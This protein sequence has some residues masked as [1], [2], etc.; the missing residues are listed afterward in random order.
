MRVLIISQYFWPEDFRIND[1][2]KGLVERGHG[3][4][5]LTGIPNYPGG[6]FFP[7]YSW[8]KNL[9]QI[10]HGAR[11]LRVPLVS[12]G[13]SGGVRLFL[14]YLSF[15]L[16]SCLLAPLRC[17]EKYD[18]IFV[19]QLSPVTVGL[20]AI[21][22]RKIA[23]IPVFFWVQDLWP[24]SLS[25]TGSIR[26]K[27]ILD[28]VGKLVGFIYARCERILI[29]SQAFMP[30]IVKQGIDSSRVFFLPNSVERTY[31]AGIDH[32]RP[33]SIPALP[34]GFRVMFAGNI[35]VAQD[36][37]TI[38]AVAE[39]LKSHLDIHM[40]VLGDGR[41]YGWVKEQVEVRSLAGTVHLLG[42][43]PVD[44]M[45]EFFA[46]ADVMLVT[47]KK[48]P[49]FALTIPAKIQSY[50]ACGKPIVAA[51]DGEGGR[52]V[53]QS[54]AGISVPAEDPDAIAGAVLAMYSMS[55]EQREEMGRRGLAYCEANFDREMLLDR[56]E[57]WMRESVQS[58][59]GT[60]AS[61]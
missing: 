5:V 12:R 30:L 1:L 8:F 22:M 9:T 16:S 27:W 7:G 31:V 58:R 42:R 49:I 33:T 55:Q 28:V 26:S 48:E 19:C 56:L 47:L 50:M 17:R 57:G 54:G 38:L 3:V 20:P 45:S 32:S 46:E 25:A 53:S 2:A 34:K 29:Q 10:Y 11:V 51:I 61:S 60:K 15:A 37:G 21:L 44:T 39:K 6:R 59:T 52:L 41:R 24:E 14:N 40:V 18:L 13:N 35:G 23:K 43:Y 4:T 36:F